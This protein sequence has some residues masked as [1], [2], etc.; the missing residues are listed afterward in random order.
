MSVKEEVLR[1]QVSVDNM[2]RMQVFQRERDFGRV[3]FGDSVRKPLPNVSN[4]ATKPLQVGI[5]ILETSEAN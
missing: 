2:L 4:D 5:I 3:E 1:F